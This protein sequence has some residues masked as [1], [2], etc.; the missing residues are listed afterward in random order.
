MFMLDHVSLS[1]CVCKAR[2]RTYPSH[3]L[4]A[5]G[6][7]SCFSAMSLAVYLGWDF[8]VPGY[9]FER[10]VMGYTK[11]GLDKKET[12]WQAHRHHA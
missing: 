12:T 6:G 5:V 7:P 8:L 4:D 9:D 11:V 1:L 10:M 2:V 3:R